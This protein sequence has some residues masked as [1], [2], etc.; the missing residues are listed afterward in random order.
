LEDYVNH[1]TC[2]FAIWDMERGEQ[3]WTPL[4]PLLRAAIFSFVEAS[5][6]C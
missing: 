4:V 1:L 6:L 2:S 5:P 3:D